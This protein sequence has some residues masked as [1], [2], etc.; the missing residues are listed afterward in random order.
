MR[1]LLYE[2][3]QVVIGYVWKNICKLGIL[4]VFF[5]AAT[6]SPEGVTCER[7]RVILLK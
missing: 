3:R 2:E 5:L 1:V 7:M 6:V 4:N